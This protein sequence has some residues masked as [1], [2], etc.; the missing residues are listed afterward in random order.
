MHMGRRI[1][2]LAVGTDQPA[3]AKNKNN[4]PHPLNP[5]SRR[6]GRRP[7]IA[8]ARPLG[9]RLPLPEEVHGRHELHWAERA[10]TVTPTEARVAEGLL[11]TAG[12]G[13][14]HPRAADSA[15]RRA[16]RRRRLHHCL[17][18]PSCLRRC[19][20]RRIRRC[21][22]RHPR[23][24]RRLGGR[25][26]EVDRQSRK[27]ELARRC[28]FCC[29]GRRAVEDDRQ[30]REGEIA[31]CLRCCCRRCCSRCRHRDDGGLTRRRR[32]EK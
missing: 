23:H 22:C 4:K 10:T 26:A 25:A 7:R 32:G 1:W 17:T 14:A 16:V 28:R 12:G 15:H 21:L 27:G 18:K 20:C 31:N 29:L 5:R 11:A 2:L 6:A 19:P 24:P 13:V 30:R 8:M 9:A 3:T